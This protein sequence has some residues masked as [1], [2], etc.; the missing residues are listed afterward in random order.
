MPNRVRTHT[1][2]DLA[3]PHADRWVAWSARLDGLIT[4]SVGPGLSLLGLRAGQL[5]GENFLD[6]YADCPRTAPRFR[7]AVAGIPAAWIG[8]YGG[9]W[10][11]GTMFPVH[12]LSGRVLSVAGSA[13]ILT[14]AEASAEAT[15][16]ALPPVV[17]EMEED[18]IPLGAKGDLIHWQ[19]GRSMV[20]LTELPLHYQAHLLNPDAPI[21][22]LEA[23]EPSA[24][25][26][27]AAPAGRRLT[28][29]RE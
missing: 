12:A 2:A 10:M 11:R 1:Y 9:V 17:F 14:A 3:Y 7:N 23:A 18:F 22:C 13:V 8:E 27:P 4:T 21:R 5:V 25:S 6:L 19:A 29:L 26:A 24:P 15:E 28:L 20:R 16:A